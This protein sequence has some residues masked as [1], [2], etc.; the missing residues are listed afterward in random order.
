MKDLS[1][2]LFR[3]VPRYVLAK[4]RDPLHRPSLEKVE[5]SV[6]VLFLDLENC[7]RLCEDL[8][9]R[10]MNELIET[11]FSRF[12][13]V[14][15]QAGGLINEIMGDG[16]MA[17]FE[18]D[19]HQ[20]N[21]LS[22][23][24]AAVKIQQQATELNA[25]RSKEYEPVLVNIGIHAGSA[26]VGLTKFRTSSGERWTYTASGSVSNVAARLCAKATNGSI[27]VSSDVAEQV[28]DAGYSLERLGPQELKNVSQTVIVFK[29]NDSEP[30]SAKTRTK[31]EHPQPYV[32]E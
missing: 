7:T 2:N 11:Y 26:L 3:C 9:P 17:I 23:A 16:F 24:A 22:A 5:K 6:A 20:N 27:L 32:A 25:L 28:K 14:I 18:Q 12:F 21:I 19:E 8:P 13:D 10:E 31:T 1:D 15:E 29:L 4:W 30:P